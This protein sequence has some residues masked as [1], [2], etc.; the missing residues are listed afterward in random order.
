MKLI[1]SIE[2]SILDPN[3]VEIAAEAQW[4][5]RVGCKSDPLL[6]ILFGGKR[7]TPFEWRVR[8]YSLPS[9]ASTFKLIYPPHKLQGLIFSDSPFI[10]P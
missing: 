9:I 7:V 8:G 4:H 2:L 1:S 5:G 3:D 6:L 10:R